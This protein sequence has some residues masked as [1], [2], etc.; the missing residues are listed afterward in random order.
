MGGDIP[1]LY[2]TPYGASSASNFPLL[3]LTPLH[4]ILNTPLDWYLYFYFLFVLGFHD[5]EGG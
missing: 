5:V 2:S 4:K 3:A 1:S